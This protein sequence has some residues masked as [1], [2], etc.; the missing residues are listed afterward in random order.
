MLNSRR[1]YAAAITLALWTIFTAAGAEAQEVAVHVPSSA[2]RPVLP[3]PFHMR[4]SAPALEGVLLPRWFADRDV[5]PG[6]NRRGGQT[7]RNERSERSLVRK[8]LGAAVGAAGGFFAG[9]FLGAAI[10]G[11]RCHCDDPGLKGFLIGAPVGAT[12]GGILGERYLF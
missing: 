11:D 1:R 8:L 7:V 9:G 12:V 5:A 4:E 10:E 6:V 3:H 2:L